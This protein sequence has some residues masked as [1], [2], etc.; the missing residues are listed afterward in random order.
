MKANLLKEAIKLKYH[1]TVKKYSFVRLTQLDT[2]AKYSASEIGVY[3]PLDEV[4]TSE[5]VLC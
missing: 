2:A 3:Q 4:C 1:I 5:L